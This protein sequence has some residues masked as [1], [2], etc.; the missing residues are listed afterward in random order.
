MYRIYIQPV[1]AQAKLLSII[2]NEP[3]LFHGSLRLTTAA[4]VQFRQN[5]PDVG[6]DGGE[7]DVQ[8]RTNLAGR[9][10]REQHETALR[11]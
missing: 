7:L 6:L 1:Q 4:D 5:M 8:D 3:Q 11:T 10:A 9:T 2:R